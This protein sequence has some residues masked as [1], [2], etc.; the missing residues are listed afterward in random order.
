M[1]GRSM[2]WV[3]KG[4]LG[5]GDVSS[6][7]SGGG[8]EKFSWC[9]LDG[10]AVFGGRS[11]E[12]GELL[13]GVDEL[14]VELGHE[15]VQKDLHH[16]HAELFS[17]AHSGTSAERDERVEIGTLIEPARIEQLRIW[18]VLLSVMR[19]PGAT[20][21]LIQIT[22]AVVR[23]LLAAADIGTDRRPHIL[24]NVDSEQ[25]PVQCCYIL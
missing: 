17:W 4:G 13:F 7:Q 20:S 10:Q 8:L 16:G 19:L 22:S 9:Q 24:I 3:G 11:E 1:C 14:P 25:C 6:P 2:F 15:M 23:S 5:W 21:D 12:H 18:E